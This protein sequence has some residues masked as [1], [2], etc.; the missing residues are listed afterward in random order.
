MSVV[1]FK[2]WRLC[3]VGFYSVTLTLRPRH[4]LINIAIPD[5]TLGLE[6]YVCDE[7]FRFP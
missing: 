2:A 5:W 3:T 7:I 6:Q 1:K 4:H